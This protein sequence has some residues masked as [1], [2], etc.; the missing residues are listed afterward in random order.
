MAFVGKEMPVG[1]FIGLLA[2]VRAGATYVAVFTDIDHH[3]HPASACIDVFNKAESKPTPFMVGDSKVLLSNTRN[4][5]NMYDPQDLTK[6][7]GYKEGS[8]RS[9]TVRGKN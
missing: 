7:L 5:V 3:S 2:A 6:A 4:W 9:D 1:I 8:E